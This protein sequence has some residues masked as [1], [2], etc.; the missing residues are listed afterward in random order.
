MTRSQQAGFRVRKSIIRFAWWRRSRISDQAYMFI[1]AVLIGLAS[2]ACAWLLKHMIGAVSSWV[3]KGLNPD[4]FNYLLLIVPLAAIMLT[5]LLTRRVMRMR[6]AHSV[7]QL[8][9]RLKRKDYYESPRLMAYPMIA[10]TLTLGLGGSAGSEG[11]I[12]ATG[13]A[14]GGNLARWSRLSPEM[15]MVLIG[16]GAGAGIAGIFKAPMGGALF[17][18]EVL[19]LGLSTLSILAVIVASI[20][21]AMTAY[22]LGGYTTDLTMNGATDVMGFDHFGW[23][24]VLGIICG[25][26]SL[27]YSWIM[28]RVEQWLMAIGRPWV[29]NL[30]AGSTLAVLIA[31]FP[32]LYGE[33]YGVAG[34]L[35]N[36]HFDALTADGLFASSSGMLT[37]AAVALATL[38]VKCFATSAT[39]SGGGVAGDFA[40][41]LMAGSVCG[42]A[43][44]VLANLLFDSSLSPE[45]FALM[46]M[47]GVMAG[48]IRAPLMAIMLTTEMVGSYSA[49]LPIL[50]VASISFGVVRFFTADDFFNPHPDRPNGIAMPKTFI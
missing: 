23:L 30:I 46:G 31:L 19:R 10:S 14:I 1:L 32:A 41:T 49:M 36:G 6:L 22:W 34:N 37:L 18:F 24:I 45:Q 29:R 8:K 11:P 9:Q 47:A 42:F 38:A 12:A 2:G 40:P 27:Y 3:A 26:Y 48:A 17:T 33:G 16:C 13:A 20:V 50:I 4:G 7:R 28:K 39:N 15:V 25:A 5:G 35:L 21:A 43:V 44:A